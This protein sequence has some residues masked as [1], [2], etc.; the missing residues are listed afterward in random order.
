M[1]IPFEEVGVFANGKRV[2]VYKWFSES[3]Q[4]IQER[5]YDEPPH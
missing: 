1:T 5:S 2:G 3:G 4:L